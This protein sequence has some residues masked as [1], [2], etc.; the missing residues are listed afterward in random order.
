MARVTGDG[1]SVS[2]SDSG[3]IRSHTCPVQRLSSRRPRKPLARNGANGEAALSRHPMERQVRCSLPALE[4]FSRCGDKAGNRFRVYEPTIGCRS[5]FNVAPS[6][7]MPV[8]VQR[9][10]AEMVAMEWGLVPHWVK[11]PQGQP[12][13]RSTPGPR[14]SPSGPCSAGC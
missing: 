2:V 1:I 9:E 4:H 11:D 10:T 12:T 14:R 13:G 3:A 7:T 6:Q 5:R 8:V